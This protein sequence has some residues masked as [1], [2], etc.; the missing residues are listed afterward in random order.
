MAKFTSLGVMHKTKEGGA[1]EHTGEV[2][3]V[4]VQITNEVTEKQL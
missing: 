3:V 1:V 4:Y 2:W